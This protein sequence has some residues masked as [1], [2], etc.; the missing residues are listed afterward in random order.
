[1]T[2]DGDQERDGKAERVLLETIL[3]EIASLHAKVDALHAPS[4][5][6]LSELVAAIA[7]F[8]GDAEFTAGELLRESVDQPLEK[9]LAGLS[10]RRVGKL[11]RR[12]EGRA[13]GQATIRRIGECREGILWR[14]EFARDTR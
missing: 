3:V 1:V 8:V 10:A 4:T 5:D 14:C 6:H 2:D 9:H 13:F 11:L 12:I 7:A